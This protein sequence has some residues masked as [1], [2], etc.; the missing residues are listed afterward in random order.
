VVLDLGILGGVCT[1]SV[2]LAFTF[3]LYIHTKSKVGTLFFHL[4]NLGEN[5][6]NPLPKEMKQVLKLIRDTSSTYLVI[7]HFFSS[8]I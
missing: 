4:S 6:N 8:F 2:A 5:K 7:A 1:C 3:T